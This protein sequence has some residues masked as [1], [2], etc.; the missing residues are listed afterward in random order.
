[1]FDN[2][3]YLGCYCG[4][5]QDK[6]IPLVVLSLLYEL[7]WTFPGKNSCENLACDENSSQNANP[8]SETA[9]SSEF[10]IATDKVYY[11]S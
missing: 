4:N 7:H 2:I 10:V 8:K 9:L 5:K 11:L 3:F 1:M 6:I